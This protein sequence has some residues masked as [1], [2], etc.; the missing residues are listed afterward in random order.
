[1]TGTV[2]I[3]GAGQ[4]GYAASH[5][6]LHAGWDVRLLARSAPPWS[7]KGVR[8]E[9]YVAGEHTPPSAD[10]VLDTIAYDADDVERY[11]PGAVGRLITISSASVYVDYEGRTL[12]SAA[13]T[14]FPDFALGVDEEGPTVLPG[15]QTYSTRK[16]RMEQKAREMFDRRSTN[17]RP[18]A[19]Y[20]PWCRHPREW[21]FVNRFKDRRRIIPLAFE[22]QS[23]FH[24][25]DA[26][27][28][29]SL[30]VTLSN[31][32]LGGHFNIADE[33]APTVK[34]IGETVSEAFGKRVR[35]YLLEGPPVG[36]VGRTPWSLPYP[37]KIASLKALDAGF[38]YT[39]PPFSGLFAS[40]EWL[41]A[42]RFDDWRTAFPVMAGYPFDPFDYAAEDRFFDEH[43]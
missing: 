27:D 36:T 20:G 43:M 10:V 8:F 42:H 31:A 25:T 28:I 12:E 9:N 26:N 37:F 19:I 18:G 15:P 3:I 16:V 24:I 34:E 1:M 21:W 13:E 23:Q 29:G 35:F 32:E 14:G 6:F 39:A 33:Y 2:A 41:R 17:I 38:R 5:A 30:A 22:G 7:I 40:I 4:I 11:D